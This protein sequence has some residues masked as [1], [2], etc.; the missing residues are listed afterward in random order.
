M[1]R[2]FQT[3]VLQLCVGHHIVNGTHLVH[4][5]RIILFGKEKDFA[6]KLLPNLPRQ[7]RRTVARVERANSRIGLLKLA[8][9]FGGYGQIRN[10]MQGMPAAR[11]PPGDQS[12]HN[13]GHGTNQALHLQNMQPPSTCRVNRFGGV[14]AGVVVAVAPADALVTAR[15]ERPPAIFGGGAVPCQ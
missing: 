2:V 11:S 6:R 1:S 7:K 15:A 4:A 3:L 8:V 10:H 13:L 5:L 12:D 14:A 9:L